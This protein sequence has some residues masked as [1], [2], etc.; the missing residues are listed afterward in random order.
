MIQRII[1]SMTLVLVLAMAAPVQAEPP[2]FQNSADEIVEALSKECEAPRTRGMTRGFFVSSDKDLKCRTVVVKERE[3]N[4]VVK[5]TITVYPNRPEPKANLNIEFDYDSYRIRP[6]AYSLLNEL[7]KALTGRK[8]Q[9]Q[10]FYV[11]GHT[12]A[13]GPQSYNLDLSLNRAQAVKDYLVGNFDIPPRRLNVRGYGEA[14][15]LVE[16]TTP[17]KRQINRRVEIR[18]AE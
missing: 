8:L 18:P 10:T 4:H 1:L 3:E 16:N 13:D 15:P 14:M 11:N 6:G 12:D 17:T 2:A 7:G 5:Q 9:G